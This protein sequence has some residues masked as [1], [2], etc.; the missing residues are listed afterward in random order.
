MAKPS[1]PATRMQAANTPGLPGGRSRRARGVPADPLGSLTQAGHRHD[2]TCRSCGS[3]RVTRLAM[4]L[5]DGTPVDF[6]SCHVCE[7]RSW[8]HEG[9]ELRVDDVLDKAK[10]TR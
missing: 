1:T 3:T 10:R 5:T 7:T 8:A 6:V 4:T 2:T 9:R